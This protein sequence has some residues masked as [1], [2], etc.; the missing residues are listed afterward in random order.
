MDMSYSRV[1]SSMWA[2]AAANFA[3]GTRLGEQEM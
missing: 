3:M 1:I 2:W